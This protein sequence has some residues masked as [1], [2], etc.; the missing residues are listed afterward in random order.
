M[1]TCISNQNNP[2]ERFK[3]FTLVINYSSWKRKKTPKPGTAGYDPNDTNNKNIPKYN[4]STDRRDSSELPATENL[5][6]QTT[7]GKTAVTT[8]DTP[9]TN[10]GNGKYKDPENEKLIT[11]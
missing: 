3:P 2:L 11:P 4:S 9:K 7:E 8:P 6:D 10:L 1:I 5:N